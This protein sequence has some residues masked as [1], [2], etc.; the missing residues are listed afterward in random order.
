MVLVYIHPFLDGNGRTSR[1][2]STLCLYRSGYDFKRLF[3]LSEYYDRNRQAFYWALQ[4]VRD[5]G[6]D[7]TEWLEYFV[8]GLATQ[9]AE[10]RQRGERVIRGDV[11]SKEYRLTDRQ[12]K[13]L[14]YIF[15]HG[16]LTIQK[17]ESLCP[18]VNRRSLQRDLRSMI[19]KGL[20]GSSGA[21]NKLVYR[22]KE[23]P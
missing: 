20:L 7:M 9:L 18:E 5:N 8:K 3:T 16:S 19:D 23:K 10:V 2:L 6:M 14:A 4:S 11:L 22:L 1:L 17:Y 12:S 21:T 15:E 13:A